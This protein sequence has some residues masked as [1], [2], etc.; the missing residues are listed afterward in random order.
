MDFPSIKHPKS[1]Q[2]LHSASRAKAR[3]VEDSERQLERVQSEFLSIASHELR[4]PLTTIR[5]NASMIKQYYW[6]SIQSDDAKR[7]VEDIHEASVRLI[8]M[9]NDLLDTLKLEQQLLEFKFENFDVVEV[10]KE[11][12]GHFHESSVKSGT[13]I[14]VIQEGHSIPRVYAD[15]TRTRQ[16][17]LSLVDNALKATD[18]GRILIR[19]SEVGQGVRVRVSDNGQGIPYG[20]QKNLFRRFE[21][22]KEDILTRDSV[23]GTG[24]GLYMSRLIM[25][26]MHG[27][28]QLDHSEPGD[29]TAFSFT[30]PI[31]KRDNTAEEK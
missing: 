24:L 11:V 6:D 23:S 21:Q 17:L 9:V 5:G 14:E 3:S 10:A 2:S 29:G 12:I 30:L 31:E 26:Q 8:D 16:V 27:H 22:A 25:E 15:K 1:A 13:A 18:H 20:T 19:V 4:T 7:M 28:I